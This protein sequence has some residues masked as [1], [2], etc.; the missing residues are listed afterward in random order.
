ME[1]VVYN[2]SSINFNIQP[3]RTCLINVA[4]HTSPCIDFS[5]TLSTL[6]D[7]EKNKIS[8]IQDK[9]KPDH[10]YIE[11]DNSE[12]GLQLKKDHHGRHSFRSVNF[13]R[14]FYQ[15]TGLTIEKRYSIQVSREPIDGLY[16]IITKSAT[17][18]SDKKTKI[19]K[20]QQA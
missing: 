5:K 6:L 8:F 2:R 19:H 3:S 7:L 16:A 9:N 17:C 1:R 12:N 10:W 18:R 14:L 15:S 13:I 4:A 11:I 20:L